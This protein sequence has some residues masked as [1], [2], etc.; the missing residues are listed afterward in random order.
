MRAISIGLLLAASTT[1][2]AADKV[3]PFNVKTGQWETTG[4]NTVSGAM[5]I[6]DALLAK[7]SPEQRARMEERMKANSGGKTMPYTSRSCVTKEDLEKVPKFGMDKQS[8]TTTVLTSTGTKA[9]IRADCEMQ[10][11]KASWT[12]QFE[13]L[14]TESVKGSGHTIATGNGHSMN[15]TSSFTSKWRG[16]TCT[17][18]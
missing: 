17:K 6:P 1:G 5:P 18:E 7:L 14:S 8:C 3:Q 2:L 15:V 16:A 13:A 4:T 11:M 9:E 12:M 10:G